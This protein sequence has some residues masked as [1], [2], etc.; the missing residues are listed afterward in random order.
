MENS[1]PNAPATLEI[2][3]AFQGRQ[4][5]PGD[6]GYDAARAV[7]NG[8]VDKRPTLIARCSG[9]ADVIDAVALAREG[10]L[11]LA[12][13]CG[14]HSV[15]GNGATEGGVLIDLSGMKGVHVN[16]DARVA[17]ANGGVL[18]GEFDRETQVY[19]LATP[20]GRVTTTGVGGFTLGGG[21]G[22]LSTKW[23]LA[24]DNLFSAQVVTADGRVVTASADENADLLWGLR[25]GGG[26]FGVVTSYEF[27]LHE[28]DPIVMAG[29]VV[30]PLDDAVEIGRA[31]REWIEAAPPEVGSAFIVFRAPPEPFIP[32]ELHGKPAVMILAMFAGDA[33][34]GE[35]V[36]RPLSKQIGGPPA[37]D[38]IDRMP[39]TAF[40]TIVDPFSPKGWL[41]YHRGEHLA[42]LSDDAIAA[43]VEHGRRAT[44]PMSYSILFRHGGAISAVDE[45]ATAF[46]HRDAPYM[47][48]PIA[49]WTDPADTEREVGWVREASSAMAPFTTGGVYLNFE[50]SIGDAHVRA[51]FSPESYARLVGLKDRWDPDNL[52]HINPNIPPSH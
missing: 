47:W 8:M 31:W 32:P 51:G 9:T 26:N 4:F 11:P 41:N 24:C 50:A 1:A 23:G 38:G 22:W 44:S 43:F 40:Q 39:Y 42:G 13:R 45:E 18:W 21:Y 49:A 48:H 34:E 37:A 30:H 29:L 33:D 20:G 2:A 52:F 28:L 16:P 27:R 15:A 10:K 5:R 3:P 35:E 46:G 12:V 7:Y 14:G 25:G 36:L 19:G 17:H 6:D